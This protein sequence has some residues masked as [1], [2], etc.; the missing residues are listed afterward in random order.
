MSRMRPLQTEHE[1]EGVSRMAE[2]S[3]RFV[4]SGLYPH[5]VLR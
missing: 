5:I 4:G 2:T 3:E 1:A